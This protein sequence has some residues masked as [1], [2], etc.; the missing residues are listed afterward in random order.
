MSGG[1]AEQERAEAA[2]A[3]QA[4]LLEQ[5][6]SLEHSLAEITPLYRHVLRDVSKA[7][8]RIDRRVMARLNPPARISP[9]PVPAVSP[10]A[11]VAELLAAA[12][13]TDER[14][15]A[16][17]HRPLPVHRLL[18]VYDRSRAAVR[19]RGRTLLRRLARR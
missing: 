2:R 14:T 19:Q 9:A 6:R 3:D 15:A 12:Q 16:E 18:P 17:L 8:D 11:G 13:A 1:S 4:A 10:D 5:I 7:Y